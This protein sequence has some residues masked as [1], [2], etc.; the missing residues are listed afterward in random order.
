M[1]LRSSTLRPLSYLL[2][3]YQITPIIPLRPILAPVQNVRRICRVNFV[4][5]ASSTTRARRK[6]VV[7]LL[8]AKNNKGRPQDNKRISY[9]AQAHPQSF[10]NT[11]PIGSESEDSIAALIVASANTRKA[12]NCSTD[13]AGKMGSPPLSFED[14][15]AQTLRDSMAPTSTP[16]PA[17]SFEN[18]IAMALQGSNWQRLQNPNSTAPAQ[19]ELFDQS[20]D[21]NAA[22]PQQELFDQNTTGL[23]E[24]LA[25]SIEE[26]A[27]QPPELT[28]KQKRKKQQFERSVARDAG[29][30]LQSIEPGSVEPVAEKVTWD[31]DPELLCSYNWQETTDDTNT[32]FGE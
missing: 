2:P 32:I 22:A 5:S 8:K 14:R 29:D 12:T 27:N 21:S 11:T 4:Q 31:E 24:L 26:E 10:V 13:T 6:W 1:T 20:L 7:K 28:A 18:K 15:I 3:S 23:E 9:K 17:M 25:A 30:V 19:S 16:P